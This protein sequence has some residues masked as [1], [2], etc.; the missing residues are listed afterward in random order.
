M[1]T[2]SEQA[3]IDKISQREVFEAT[4]EAVPLA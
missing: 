3:I 4:I 2:L 1:S